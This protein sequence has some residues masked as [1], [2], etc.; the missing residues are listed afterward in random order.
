MQF[1]DAEVPARRHKAH[2]YCVGADTMCFFSRPL[3]RRH[4]EV[5]LP[6]VR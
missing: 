4:Q 1:L 5:D 6:C 3:I 2:L